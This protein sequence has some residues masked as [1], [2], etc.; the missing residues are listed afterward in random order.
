MIS[1]ADWGKIRRIFI[2]QISSHPIL[3]PANVVTEPG[4]EVE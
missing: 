2:G 3:S 4:N 1:L